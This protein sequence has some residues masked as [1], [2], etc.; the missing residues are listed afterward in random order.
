MFFKSQFMYQNVFCACVCL[1]RMT[2]DPV[3]CACESELDRLFLTGVW[4]RNVQ[5]WPVLMTHICAGQMGGG[6][7]L[8]Q[9]PN[10]TTASSGRP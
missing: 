1:Y 9:L 3:L 4:L 2:K 10:I 7:S 5:P 6:W 8:Q